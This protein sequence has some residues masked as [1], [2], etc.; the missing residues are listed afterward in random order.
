MNKRSKTLLKAIISA[1]LA[2]IFV[3]TVFASAPTEVTKDELNS[4]KSE[5]KELENLLYEQNKAME[6][7]QYRLDGIA[8]SIEK[9]EAE[10]ELLIQ[11]IEGL[12]TDI[13]TTEQLIETYAGYIELKEEEIRESEKEMARREE[14]LIEYLRYE[15]EQG[16]QG[17]QYL[18]FLLNSASL[19]D[20]LSSIHYIGSML[21]Y[22]EHL[23]DDMKTA[24]IRLDSQK[25]DLAEAK[26][27]Q[28]EYKKELE[29]KY[30]ESIELK[31]EIDKYIIELEMA[32]ATEDEIYASMQDEL[33]SLS[34]DISNAKSELDD[35]Q[36]DYD[37]WQEYQA[38]LKRQQE[39][40]ERRRQEA[41]AQAALN[42]FSYSNDGRYL[43]PI[44]ASKSFR[45]STWYGYEPNPIGS[46]IRFH[47]AVDFALASGNDIY[48]IASGRVITAKYSSSYGYYVVLLHNDGT[49]S[50]YAH[51]S[52][53]KVSVGDR[54]TQGDVI[55][56]VGSTG[57]STGAHLHF[58]F[59]L[60][61]GST[62]IDPMY[63]YTAVYKNH[64]NDSTHNDYLND[65]V[66]RAPRP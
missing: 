50:L 62:R 49:S 15:Y 22:Q 20:F 61:D 24:L 38:E 65:G 18:E 5:I 31:L 34:S 47:K 66:D 21:D 55:A 53:L 59:I 42:K 17:V 4:K 30:A 23:M 43:L 26:A 58:E 57:W 63:L 12:A 32:Y 11:K 45:I 10:K 27:A 36:E 9:S 6:E 7:L 46:G 14:L 52:R 41:E 1:M 37:A 56:L 19:S 28:E 3:F 54:V 48:A 39:E 25:A 8:D 40:E 16:A 29:E 64:Y 44:N 35:L 13:D 33:G 2:F 51:A 60:E